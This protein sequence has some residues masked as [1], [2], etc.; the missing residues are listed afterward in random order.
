M[1]CVIHFLYTRVTLRKND[2]F[3]NFSFPLG[4]ERALQIIKYLG[5]VICF[6]MNGM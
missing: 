2:G 6:T 4:Y 5:N 1:W 3:K